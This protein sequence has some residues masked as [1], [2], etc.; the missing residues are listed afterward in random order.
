ML[1]KI[2][3]KALLAI[4]IIAILFNITSKLVNRVSLESTI[5]S[6]E[7]GV[8]VKELFNI[9]DEETTETTTD[10]SSSSSYYEEDNEDETV[11]EEFYDEEV[12]EEEV[13]EEESEDEEETTDITSFTTLLY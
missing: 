4:C 11:E 5:T 13:I 12:V 9:V 10:T 6:A 2:W 7:D 3:K 1:S 8:D